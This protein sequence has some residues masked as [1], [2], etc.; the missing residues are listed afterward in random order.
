MLVDDKEYRKYVRIR[1]LKASKP[2]KGRDKKQ[3]NRR[4]K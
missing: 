4:Y 1:K 3:N 2:V